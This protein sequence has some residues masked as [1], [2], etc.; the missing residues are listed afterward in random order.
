MLVKFSIITTVKNGLS[1]LKRTYE[2][3][4]KQS[5]YDFEWIVIDSNS[6]DGTAEWL[7]SLKCEKFNIKWLSESDAGIADGY[8]KGIEKSGSPYCLI[9][10]AGDT[11]DSDA[12]K[13]F[14][15][16]VQPDIIT[17]SHARLLNE[18]GDFIKVF[19]S[20]PELLWRGM[21]LPHNWC[22]VPKSFYDR[23]GGYELIPHSLD[24]KWF[25]KYYRA[26]GVQGFKVID[27][28]LGSYYLGGHSDK[29]FKSGF[30]A[31]KIIFIEFGMS[32]LMANLL[33]ILYVSKHAIKML[34]AK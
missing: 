34:M 23:Y 4:L 7:S 30:H 2:S 8:N 33:Y 28:V 17:C 27:A 19:K 15:D 3:L 20:K 24:F 32:K 9:L 5:L 11:Y 16:N 25:Y 10:N 26:N 22:C 13:T 12:I 6:S 1:D 18:N 31:N 14:D 21:H 29:N